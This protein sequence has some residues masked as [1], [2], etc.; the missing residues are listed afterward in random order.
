PYAVPDGY[1]EIFGFQI[2]G[3]DMVGHHSWN[4]QL[5]FGTGRADDVQFAA[6]YSYL[7]LWPSF[8]TG[9]SHA[10]ERRGGF[11]VNGTDIGWDADLWPVGTG[12]DLPTLRRMAESSDLQLSY[13]WSW[14]TNKTTAPTPAIDPSAPLPQFPVTGSTAGVGVTWSYANTHRYL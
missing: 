9:V 14:V 13:S 12:V 2:A 4:L 5:G 6:N 3:S 11:I 8:N 10:L 7:G 1:G